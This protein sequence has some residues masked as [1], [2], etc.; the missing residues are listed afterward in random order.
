MDQR[1][2]SCILDCRLA[3][4]LSGDLARD[5]LWTAGGPQS[6]YRTSTVQE[7][8]ESGYLEPFASGMAV[9]ITPA[10]LAALK[11]RLPDHPLVNSV[12]QNRAK[13]RVVP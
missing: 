2:M 8:I 7:L 12:Q 9:R 3:G 10:G 5:T 4:S 13:W 11:E 1:L 6:G